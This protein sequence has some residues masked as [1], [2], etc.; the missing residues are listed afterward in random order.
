MM[1]ETKQP[2]CSSSQGRVR[3][4][5]ASEVPANTVQADQKVSSWR[6]LPLEPSARQTPYQLASCSHV[7]SADA[8]HAPEAS[9]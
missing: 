1:R 3:V 9:V 7:M 5:P 8:E 2:T 6:G 4:M